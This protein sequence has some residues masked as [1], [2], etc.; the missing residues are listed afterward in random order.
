M[1]N[2]NNWLWFFFASKTRCK[3]FFGIK[4]FLKKSIDAPDPFN[5]NYVFLYIYNFNYFINFFII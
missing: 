1:I 2:P 3:Y 4:D 5:F